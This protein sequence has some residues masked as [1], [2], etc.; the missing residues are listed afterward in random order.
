MSCR[1]FYTFDLT[2]RLD[3]NATQE[4]STISDNQGM[5]HRISEHAEGSVPSDGRTI[6]R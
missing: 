3:D 6:T 2:A 4:V 1:T 5:L